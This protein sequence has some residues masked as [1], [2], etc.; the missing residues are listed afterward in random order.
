MPPTQ[1]QLAV[2]NTVDAGGAESAK[3][4]FAKIKWRHASS[5]APPD[6]TPDVALALA[7]STPATQAAH[8]AVQGAGSRRDSK[9]EQT[10]AHATAQTPQGSGSLREVSRDS[11]TAAPLVTPLGV[12]GT[13]SNIPQPSRGDAEPFDWIPGAHDDATFRF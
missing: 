10:S 3:T 8:A 1:S 13:P 6:V 11:K 5:T 4:S 12:S 7:H 9:S 2:S